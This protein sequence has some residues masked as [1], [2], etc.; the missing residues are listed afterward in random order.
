MTVCGLLASAAVAA[1][2]PATAAPDAPLKLAHSYP[3]PGDIK[4]H[5]DHFGVD[6]EGK[7]LFG[8]A[9][10]D[11]K[12]VV[13]DFGRGKLVKEIAGVQEP[14]AVLYRGDVSKLYV[15][16]GG[17]A[18]RIFDSNTFAPLKSFSVSVDADPIVYDPVTHRLFVVNGGEKAHHEYTSVT[19]F[20]TTALTQVGAVR[21]LGLEIEGMTVEFAG[22]RVF[23]N[24]R[25]K[26]Q[27]DI[28]DR[29]DFHKIGIW[30]LSRVK[31]NTVSALDETGHR[32]FV[33]GHEGQ[34]GIIDSDSGKELLI[35]DIGPG[36]DDIAYDAASRRI[37]VCGGGGSGS[38]DVF[39][40][41]D[42]D[43]Y[44]SLGRVTTQPGAATGHLV[45]EAGEYLVMAPARAGKSAQV[46][47]YSV[48][49]AR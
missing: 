37:Y 17:G 25:D 19:A 15:S 9:V 32:L 3:L 20:D 18:L 10:E 39:E 2:T 24:N 6:A 48:V 29:N 28:F 45:A 33:A 14:R 26:N 22:P 40:Q 21:L 36:A 46:L 41:T 8:T 38:V 5:F 34:L 49:P 44:R 27:I 16:D 42:A 47:V 13:F 11:R 1:G 30:P 7:R 4:G 35:L 12:V 31:R 23:A 43:H